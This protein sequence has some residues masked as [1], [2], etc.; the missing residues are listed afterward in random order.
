MKCGRTESLVT[1]L[2]RAAIEKE[3]PLWKRIASDLERPTR[4]RRIVNLWKI[5]KHAREGE[6]IVVAGKVLGDGT[7]T[8]KITLAAAAYSAEAI[9]KVTASGGKALTIEELLR[10]EPDGKGVRIIG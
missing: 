8:K 10:K 1:A 2:K 4:K 3:R 5:E 7:L 6:I 9:R